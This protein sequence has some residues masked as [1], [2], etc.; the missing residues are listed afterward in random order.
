MIISVI[1]NRAFHMMMLKQK[2]WL[3]SN[4]DEP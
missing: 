1:L 3:S 2:K 4:I